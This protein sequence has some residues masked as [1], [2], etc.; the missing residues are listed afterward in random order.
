MGTTELVEDCNIY[1]LIGYFQLNHYLCALLK[2]L[3][4]QRDGSQSVISTEQIES[5]R[6]FVYED[7]SFKEGKICQ[8]NVQ[9]KY[10]LFHLSVSV[11]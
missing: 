6:V 2:L 4:K 11:D 1:Q 8:V 7:G 9:R 10:H 5:E 3:N